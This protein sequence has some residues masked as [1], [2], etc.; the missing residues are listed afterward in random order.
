[1][2]PP[3]NDQI[4]AVLELP[5]VDVDSPLLRRRCRTV[6]AKRWW[7]LAATYRRCR[8]RPAAL[9][10]G[11]DK[12]E[13]I[14][15]SMTGSAQHLDR[16]STLASCPDQAP[17][18]FVTVLAN[19]A[20]PKA[21]VLCLMM[22]SPSTSTEVISSPTRHRSGSRIF[23]DTNVVA[24]VSPDRLRLAGSTSTRLPILAS[25]CR[26]RGYRPPSAG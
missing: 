22:R 24:H 21:G 20:C 11:I 5:P 16:S 25:S 10:S 14:E 12:P 23:D 7:C 17:A 9:L 19:H 6:R 3:Q 15:M 4:V 26:C 18:I 8:P 2:L 1:M 13:M